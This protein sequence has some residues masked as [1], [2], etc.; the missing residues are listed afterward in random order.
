MLDYVYMTKEIYKTFNIVYKREYFSL[1]KILNGFGLV[2]L[3]TKMYLCE[4]LKYYR[5]NY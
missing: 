1:M 3:C 5:N 2:I 4:K